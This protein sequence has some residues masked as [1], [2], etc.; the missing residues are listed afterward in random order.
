MSGLKNKYKIEYEPVEMTKGF[1]IYKDS[2]NKLAPYS[3]EAIYLDPNNIKEYLPTNGRYPENEEEIYAILPSDSATLGEQM[4]DNNLYIKGLNEYKSYKLSGYSLSKDVKSGVVLCG[5]TIAK[6]Y[7]RY[8]YA[9]SYI[10]YINDEGKED[11]I[12]FKIKNGDKNLIVMPKE[13]EK[14]SFTTGYLY[15]LEHKYSKTFDIEKNDFEIEYSDTLE[16]GIYLKDNLILDSSSEV[17]IYGTKS[18][19]SKDV[20]KLGFNSFYIASYYT[21]IDFTSNLYLYVSLAG[22]LVLILIVYFITYV[23]LKICYKSKEKDYNIFRTLGITKKDMQNMI[24]VEL[25]SLTLSIALISFLLVKIVTS[26]AKTSYLAIFN[27]LNFLIFI[28]YF[29]LIIVL[30]YLII[31]RFNK[32]LFKNSVSKNFKGREK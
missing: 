30:S 29:V 17:L 26:L 1:T 23:I 27:N 19:V 2:S 22:I 20:S 6:Q 4:L 3:K 14:Y 28:I 18:S 16:T 5:N 32:N 8:G 12:L 7:M 31:R 9:F 15:F 10:D 24:F 25:E 11:T 21:E 13:Y